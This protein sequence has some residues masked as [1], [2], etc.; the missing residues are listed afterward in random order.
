MACEEIAGKNNGMLSFIQSVFQENKGPSLALFCCPK[1][2]HNLK[3]CIYYKY[4][5]ILSM[6]IPRR[7]QGRK[8]EYG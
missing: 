4:N 3:N 2:A 6:V 8:E 5:C 7:P 1:N